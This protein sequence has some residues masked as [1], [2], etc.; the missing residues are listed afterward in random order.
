VLFKNILSNDNE[1][2][3]KKEEATLILKTIIKTLYTDRL[4]QAKI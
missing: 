4:G 1:S 3:N 2:M